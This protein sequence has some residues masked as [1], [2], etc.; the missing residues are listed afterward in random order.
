MST[1]YIVSTP[2]GN[3][4]D[5]SFRALRI[6]REVVLIAAED[7]RHTRKLLTHYDIQTPCISYHQHNRFARLDTIL[8]ALNKGDV[9][10]VSDAGTPALSDPGVELVR[11]CVAAHIPVCPIPGPAAPIAALITSGLPTDQFLFLGF[12]PRRNTERRA[13]LTSYAHLSVTLVCFESPY[14]LLASLHDI[15]AVLGDRQVVLAREMTK[16]HEQF[17]RGTTSEVIEHVTMNTPCGECTLVI[18]GVGKTATV[19][20]AVELGDAAT[21]EP[22]EETMI[23]RLL[24]LHEDGQS[25][26]AAARLVAKE[27]G[28]QKRVVYQ[29]WLKHQE[30]ENDVTT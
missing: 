6:L 1:L 16:M 12:L 19:G 25:S 13:L 24:E 8:D 9:A 11:A 10:L 21:Q 7:T 17:V 5:L 18:A 29:V 3:L 26:S 22:D 2:I 30:A 27:L 23:R 15:Q 4:E 28:V 20:T 14:R